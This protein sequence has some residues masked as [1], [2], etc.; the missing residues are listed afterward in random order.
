M[1][2]IEGTLQSIATVKI[3]IVSITHNILN[4]K[5][6]ICKFEEIFWEFYGSNRDTSK[7]WKLE[8]EKK[9]DFAA[10]EI[11]GQ[12][13][14]VK[15]DFQKGT[16]KAVIEILSVFG[17]VAS[18]FGLIYAIIQA[19][20]QQDDLLSIKQAIDQQSDVI[21]TIAEKMDVFENK[22]QEILMDSLANSD[23][24]IR[25]FTEENR[26]PFKANQTF[27]KIN[28]PSS[29]RVNL[30]SC[31]KYWLILSSVQI[32]LHLATIIAL[33]YVIHY[34]RIISNK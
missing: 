28:F 5:K 15:I 1:E 32:A 8:L 30:S 7:K 27:S 4:N 23:S 6:D 26:N 34:L 3:E 12:K 25:Q 31:E 33:I 19:S 13:Y 14:S 16:I 11:F 17:S 21:N 10:K 22:A 2:Q 24:R 9:I 29:K 18:I 20:N